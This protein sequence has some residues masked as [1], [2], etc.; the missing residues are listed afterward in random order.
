MA[1]RNPPH[2][3]DDDHIAWPDRA[4]AEANLRRDDLIKIIRGLKTAR[5]AMVGTGLRLLIRDGVV[6][7][8]HSSRPT[9]PPA[10][11]GTFDPGSIVADV[12]HWPEEPHR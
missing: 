12:S 5:N 2:L 7:I 6:M 3:S 10:L 11:G 4:I 8:A 9:H 1:R